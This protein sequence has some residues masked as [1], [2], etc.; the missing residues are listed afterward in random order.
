[1]AH[2]LPQ[3]FDSFSGVGRVSV[4]KDVGRYEAVEPDLFCGL[5][6]CAL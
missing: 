5:M 3:R 2:E 4:S 6:Y 1:M